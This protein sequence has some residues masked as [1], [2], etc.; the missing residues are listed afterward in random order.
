MDPTSCQVLCQLAVNV[1]LWSKVKSSPTHAIWGALIELF[2]QKVIADVVTKVFNLLSP[3]TWNATESGKFILVITKECHGFN[4][5]RDWDQQQLDIVYST[6]SAKYQRRMVCTDYD[7][8]A[9][10]ANLSTVIEW[11]SLAVPIQ[12]ELQ[13]LKLH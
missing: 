12:V 4:G 13:L 5:F 9:F 2:S 11:N 3:L 1:S 6:H 7:N 10:K 8:T